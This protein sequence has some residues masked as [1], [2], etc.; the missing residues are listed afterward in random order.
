MQMKMIFFGI[1]SIALLFLSRNTL[2][3]LK[4]HGLYR[5]VVWECILWILLQN[6]R[7]LIVEKFELKQLTSSALMIAS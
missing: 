3:S 4:N 5:C 2:I 6:Q 7:Y 1:F